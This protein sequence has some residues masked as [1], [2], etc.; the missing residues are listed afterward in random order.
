MRLRRAPTLPVLKYP[1]SRCESRENHKSGS[2]TGL[3]EA[4]GVS[5]IFLGV[6]IGRR[7]EEAKRQVTR[8]AEQDASQS[9]FFKAL[10]LS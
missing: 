2:V 5:H 10:F 1:G 4:A 7:I 8:L 3:Q 9:L 6:I